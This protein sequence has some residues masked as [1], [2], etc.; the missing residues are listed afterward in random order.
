MSVADDLSDAHVRITGVRTAADPP[1]QDLLA[2]IVVSPVFG[3]A[4]PN[5]A[6][7]ID[8]RAHSSLELLISYAYFTLVAFLIWEGNRRLHFRYRQTSDWFTRPWK[9]VAVLIGAL[10]L[11]T[12]PVAFFMLWVWGAVTG[13]PS[14]TT[15]ALV[16]AVLIVVA[17]TTFITHVYETVFLLRGWESDRLRNEKLRREAVE[18]ELEAL[19]MEV[20]PHVLFNQ[21]HALSQLVESGSA[22]AVPFVQALADSYR[23]L[24]KTQRSRTVSLEEELALLHRFA[25]LA[26]IRITGALQLQIDVS[27][28]QAS[29]YG[30]PPVTLPELLDNAVKH[31]EAT[32]ENPL[33][34]TV[35]LAGDHLV[36]SNRLS[37]RLRKVSS[38][39]VGLA[40]LAERVRLTTRSA[41]AWEESGGRFVV[42]V[43][44]VDRHGTRMDA[45]SPH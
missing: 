19:K 38:T 36:V 12:V 3:A 32:P 21:L 17:V 7:I 25:T 9:R 4:I 30:L 22:K 1:V 26:E 33:I 45:G 43:P 34:V 14:A 10:A 39:R 27:P 28:E 44:L 24:L 31:N 8:N 11:Y 41:M 16:I 15:R 2:R 23:Y 13:D 20:D 6:G 35:R 42:S 5:L 18:A 40:N 37:P 29:R